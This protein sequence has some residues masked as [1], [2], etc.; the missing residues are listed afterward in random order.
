MLITLILLAVGVHIRD[1]A[2]ARRYHS[3]GG[4]QHELGVLFPDILPI[5]DYLGHYIPT[6]ALD[7]RSCHPTSRKRSDAAKFA[8]MGAGAPRG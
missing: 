3:S 7:L 2:V 1:H 5:I 8:F 6:T 4:D